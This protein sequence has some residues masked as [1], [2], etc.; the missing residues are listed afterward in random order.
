MIEK[1][2]LLLAMREVLQNPQ[3]DYSVRELARATGL[4]VFASKQTLDY[5]LQKK[6]I[7]LKKIGKTYQYRAVL[8]NFLTRQWKVIFS[9]EELDKSMIVERILK[10]NKGILS[11]VLYGSAAIGRDDGDS[12]I[13]MLVIADTTAEGKKAIASQARGTVKEVNISVYTPEEWRKK[14]AIDKIFY[15]NVIINS[16]PL[17]GEKPVAL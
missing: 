1:Y 7:T 14:A 4:S 9:L 3:K 11:I 17:Y 6:M 16:I 13:D 5:L 12:D 8:E 2:A 15:E 10:T